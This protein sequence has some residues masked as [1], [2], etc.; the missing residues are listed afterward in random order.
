MSSCKIIK[1]GS[2]NGYTISPFQLEMVSTA[3][4]RQTEQS[5][6]AFMPFLDT[7]MPQG[8]VSAD[9]LDC[10][11]AADQGDE[12]S[13]AVVQVIG[14]PEEEHVRQVQESYDRGFEDGK[15][16]AERGLANV[17]K[18]LRDAVEDLSGMRGH[19]LRETEED[20]L[21]LVFR[22]ARK[23]IHQEITTDRLI[24]AKIVSAAVNSS[25]ERD[26]IVLRLNPEDHRLVTAHKNLYLNGLSEDRQLELK[27]DDSVSPGGCIVDTIMGEIDAR[28]ETQL[29][30]MFRRLNE[31][32]NSSVNLGA[33]LPGEREPYAYEEN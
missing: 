3:C 11:E 25:S 2:V 32:K 26:E 28:A 19:I 17:F 33:K 1:P 27:A 7:L 21:K 22:I 5:D 30:E 6:S 8:N 9:P 12:G 14:I 4:V 24:L 23:V 31:E 10:S 18:A 20:I 29:D 16:Q 15:R 13:P